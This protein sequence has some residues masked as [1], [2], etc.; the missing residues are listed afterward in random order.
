MTA[1]QAVEKQTQLCMACVHSSIHGFSVHLLRPRWCRFFLLL[2]IVAYW[3]TMSMVA[4][5]MH[6]PWDIRIYVIMIWVETGASVETLPWSPEAHGQFPH[7]H[8]SIARIPVS[9]LILI[10]IAI[11]G[12]ERSIPG[13]RRQCRLKLTHHLMNNSLASRGFTCWALNLMGLDTSWACTR[14]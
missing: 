2:Q 12:Y 9:S 14:F 7:Q 6:T 3:C 1:H 8:K 4:A 5:R 11:S 10:K 13:D